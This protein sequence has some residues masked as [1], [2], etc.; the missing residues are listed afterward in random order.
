MTQTFD[1]QGAQIDTVN[2]LMGTLFGIFNSII[3]VEYFT[4]FAWVLVLLIVLS[5]MGY[6][7]IHQMGKLEFDYHSFLL[8]IV[9]SVLFTFALYE[10]SK[11]IGKPISL[12]IFWPASPPIIYIIWNLLLMYVFKQR[13]I[14]RVK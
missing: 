3:A 12:Q 14:T 10:H 8:N 5:I 13:S 2:S 7:I 6:S 4:T 11:N 1:V 9:L